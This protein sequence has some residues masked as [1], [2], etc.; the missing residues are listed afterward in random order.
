MSPLSL[1]VEIHCRAT[2]DRCLKKRQYW[3]AAGDVVH[4]HSTSGEVFARFPLPDGWKEN[5][6]GQVCAK[7][8]A[9]VA[10]EMER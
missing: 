9:V 2:C 10:R 5:Y 3:C 8:S 1:E 4:E 7:C 6:S